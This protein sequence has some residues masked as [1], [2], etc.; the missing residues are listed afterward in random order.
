MGLDISLKNFHG[1]KMDKKNRVAPWR[2]F[3][4]ARKKVWREEFLPWIRH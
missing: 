4:T 1:I 3:R 2:G